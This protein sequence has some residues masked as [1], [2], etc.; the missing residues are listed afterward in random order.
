MTVKKTLK[1]LAVVLL[2]ALTAEPVAA[3]D[4]L[5]RQAPVDRRAKR[6]DSIEVKTFIER[7]NTR[8]PAAQI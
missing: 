1:T 5:A 7:E 8:T 4:L 2:L 6:L 3:Q